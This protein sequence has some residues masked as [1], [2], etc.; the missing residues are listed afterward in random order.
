MSRENVSKIFAI[1]IFACGLTLLSAGCSVLSESSTPILQSAEQYSVPVATG[2]LE[3][4]D[5]NEASGIAA[6]KCQPGIFWTH[7]DSEDEAQ[8]YAIDSKGA[9]LGVWKVVGAENQDWEDIAAFR[10]RAGKCYVVIGDIGNNELDREY[11]DIYRIEE[12][13]VSVP[14]ANGSKKERHQINAVQKL[15]YR[16]PDGRHNAEAL[17][18]HPETG[19]ITILTK[20]ENGPSSIYKI[21]PSFGG[22]AVTAEK[23]GEIAVPAIPNGVITGGDI[24][25]DGRRVILCDYFA[26]YELTL[27]DGAENFDLIWKQKP[28]RVDLGQRE[29]G[30]GVA[31]GDDGKYIIAVSEKPHT[32]VNIVRRKK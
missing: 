3:S 22:E 29:I 21:V 28:L 10:D 20:A 9:D 25:A 15:S 24:S 23:V 8:L 12:P 1:L 7:N 14:A 27:P 16:Y 6:S 18:V 5:L 11:M 32:P 4:G 31:Y 13:Q 19:I 26:G 2:K 30:E 17:L